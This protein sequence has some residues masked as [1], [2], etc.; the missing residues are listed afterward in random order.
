MNEELQ[1]ALEALKWE[2]PEARY[3]EQ[4]TSRRHYEAQ[5]WD[6]NHLPVSSLAIRKEH[7]AAI[8]AHFEA[9]EQR[10]A[11]LE[12]E[13]LKAEAAYASAFGHPWEV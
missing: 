9:Q 6:M 11:E 5:N 8:L 13:L 1:E 7:A 2:R 3:V 4:T 12:A 10:I